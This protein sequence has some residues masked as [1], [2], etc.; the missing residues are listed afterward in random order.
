MFQINVYSTNSLEDISKIIPRS[1]LPKECGGD[2][3]S[4]AYLTGM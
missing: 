3:E 1:L 4:V 2:G